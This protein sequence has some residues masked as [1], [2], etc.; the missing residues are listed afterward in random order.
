MKFKKNKLLD[1]FN[2]PERTAS[3]KKIVLSQSRNYNVELEMTWKYVNLV[4]L[5]VYTIVILFSEPVTQRVIPFEELS[6]LVD[7]TMT[8]ETGVVLPLFRHLN[9]ESYAGVQSKCIV[10]LSK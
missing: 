5:G 8:V 10:R 7:A 9:D 4:K 6:L 2:F 1:V 3:Y